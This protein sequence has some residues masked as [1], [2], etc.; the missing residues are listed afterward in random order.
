MS[1]TILGTG[2]ALPQLVKTNDDLRAYFD[3]SDE[4]IRTRTGILRRHIMMQETVT[5]LAAQAARHALEAAGTAPEELDYILCATVGGDYLTPSLA[6]MV[7]RALGASCPAMDVNAACSGFVYGLD[8]AA[9]LLA[10]GGLRR[11]LVVAAE[12]LSRIVDWTDRS[13]AVLF[14]DGA[15]AVVLAP[16]EDLL[17]MQLS[18]SGDAEPL[19]APYP[20]GNFPQRAQGPPPYLHMNGQDVYKF[21]VNAI[22]TGIRDALAGT[23]L[24]AEQIKHVLLH[25]ANYRIIEAACKRLRIPVERCP[26]N[27]DEIGNVSAATIPVLLDN[28]NRAGSLAPG[29][30][31]ILSAFGAGFTT[32]TCVLRWRGSPA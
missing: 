23:G 30:L 9:A 29:D 20:S 10:R 25:Q 27:I 21:A 5:D 4:W 16:G 2:S 12:G 32:G 31:I 14:G 11:V 8:M 3:T 6:C 24:A 18:A 15:G 13:T 22:Y 26:I 28:C 1:F 17:Y 19:Y 7:Q